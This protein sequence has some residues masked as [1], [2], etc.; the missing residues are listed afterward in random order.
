[1]PITASFLTVTVESSGFVFEVVGVCGAAGAGGSATRVATGTG[2]DAA[3]VI[4]GGAP[5]GDGV[6][7]AFAVGGGSST[8]AA[9]S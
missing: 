6:G 8:A 2:V 5:A 4:T 7:A 3:G 1:M 9:A